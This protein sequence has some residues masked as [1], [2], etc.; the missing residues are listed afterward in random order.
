M[1]SHEVLREAISEPGVKSV[2]ASLKVSPA[3]VYKW[4]EPSGGADDPSGTRNPLDRVRDI[5]EITKDGRVVRWLCNAAGGFFVSNPVLD[6][7]ASV[8]EQIYGETRAMFRS[9]SNF[10][11]EISTSTSDDAQIDSSEAE[12][13]RDRWE[14]L[15]ATLERFV[16]SCERGHYQLKKTK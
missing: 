9:F 16:V 10:L 6:I 15:K 12:L 8:D 5:Y 1:K 13:I 4:C 2:A 7:R 14:D 3:L 11:D